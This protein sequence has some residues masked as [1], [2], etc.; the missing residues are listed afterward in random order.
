MEHTT[1]YSH[2]FYTHHG[3]SIY[4]SF[5]NG[6]QLSFGNGMQHQYPAYQTVPQNT[7]PRHQNIIIVSQARQ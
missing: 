7:R 4:Q 6:M 1:N 3:D 5:G 2:Q